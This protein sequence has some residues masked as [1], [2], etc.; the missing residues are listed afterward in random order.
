MWLKRWI[1]ENGIWIHYAMVEENDEVRVF[2]SGREII[3]E[4]RTKY[5]S[6]SIGKI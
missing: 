3:S 5:E 6:Q 4:K 1:K 2:I